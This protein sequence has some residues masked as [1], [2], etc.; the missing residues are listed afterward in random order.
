MN[1]YFR[2]KAL[3]SI[4]I[5]FNSFFN[6]YEFSCYSQPGQWTWIHG[7]NIPNNPGSY[8]VK[9]IPGPTNEPPALYEPCEWTDLNGNFWL[10]G[11]IRHNSGGESN[12]LWK[13]DPVVNEWTWISGTQTLGDPG[14]FGIKGVASPNNR[15]PAIG[16]GAKSWTDLSGDLWMFGGANGTGGLKISSD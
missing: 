12:D 5:L 9:G 1:I 15:P 4:C 10:Y 11:G 13:Y 2:R 14:N 7:S 8:G 3:L 16:W 6:L